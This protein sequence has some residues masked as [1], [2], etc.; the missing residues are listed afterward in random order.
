MRPFGWQ[1][2]ETRQW[3]SSLCLE[4]RPQ[5]E[6][7]PFPDNPLRNGLLLCDIAQAV[8]GQAMRNLVLPP[9]DLPSA[10]RC[11]LAALDHL[12][13]MSPALVEGNQL[14]HAVRRS[15]SLQLKEKQQKLGS[16]LLWEVEQVLQG[17]RDAIWG[18]LNYIRIATGPAA[19]SQLPSF[20]QRMRAS[21]KEQ[22]VSEAVTAHRKQGK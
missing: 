19:S 22:L 20:L 17:D 14:E 15:Y 7:L 10:R 13:L 9:K 1:E 12:G 21:R 8:T 2:R 6:T 18:L 3:L 4:L 5:E 11:I 16:G